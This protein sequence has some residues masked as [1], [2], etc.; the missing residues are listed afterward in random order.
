MNT[1]SMRIDPYAM[2]ELD[3]QTGTRR[4]VVSPFFGTIE[5]YAIWYG[6]L[7]LTPMSPSFC[8]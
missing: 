2:C 5:P 8:T 1:G 4:F 3:T 7:V 6:P